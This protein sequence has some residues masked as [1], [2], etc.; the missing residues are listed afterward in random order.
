LV[1]KP[2]ER[3]LYRYDGPEIIYTFWAKHGPCQV[4][5]CGHRTPIMTTPVM[6]AKTVSIKVWGNRACPKCKRHFD[7]EQHHVRLAPD[8]P[9]MVA[10]GEEPFAVLEADNWTVCPHCGQRHQRASLGKPTKKK[11][12]AMTLL[13]HPE[14]LKGSPRIAPDGTPYGGAAQDTAASSALWNEERAKH[15]RLLEVRGALPEKVI[16]PATGVTFRTDKK[17]GTVPKRSTFLCASCGTLQDILT[18]I[19]QTPIQQ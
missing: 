5:G 11:K 1:L 13:V 4:T 16:C 2:E 18:S 9:Q 19:K 14:W 7:L 8:V 15:S 10:E 3:K 17:G 6:A 12:V